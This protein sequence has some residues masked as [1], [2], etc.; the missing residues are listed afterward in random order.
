MQGFVKYIYWRL[1][2]AINLIREPPKGLKTGTER[3]KGR[4]RRGG[5]GREGK[6]AFIHK[7]RAEDPYEMSRT[8]FGA[9]LD[10]ACILEGRAGNPYEMSRTLFW[11]ELD[12]AFIH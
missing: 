11:T 3:R 7:G 5:E 4:E 2:G 9:Q 1:V 10:F 8:I 6:G 12:F